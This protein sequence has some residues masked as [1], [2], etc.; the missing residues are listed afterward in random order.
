MNIS[1]INNIIKNFYK[2]KD[3]LGKIVNPIIEKYNLADKEIIEVCQIGK[4][5]Y[6]IKESLEIIEKPDPPRPDF[7]IK[8]NSRIIGLEHTRIFAE[9]PEKYN[10][11]ISLFKYAEQIYSNLFQN[12][13]IFASISIVNDEIKF[14]QNEKKKIA[15]DI[16]NYIFALKNNKTYEKPKFINEVSLQKHSI[17]SFHFKEKNW[18]APYLNKGRLIKEI[19]K[20]ETKIPLYKSSE[21][22]INE[23]WLVL[24]IGSL[25]SVS[26]QLNEAEDYKCNSLFDRVYLMD[27]FNAKIVRV[28]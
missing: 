27:D 13:N 22:D 1:E 8:H 2:E 12:E 3:E 24:L 23:Y 25:S 7:L 6:K 28:K 15:T 16:A 20:K 21:E 26:Y 9:N 18:Q 19:Q 10:R 17:V 4:F 5:I 14:N 11:I